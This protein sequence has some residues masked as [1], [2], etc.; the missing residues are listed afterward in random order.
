MYSLNLQSQNRRMKNVNATL[1]TI[2]DEL[3]IGQVID[4]NSSWMAQRLNEIGVAVKKRIAIGDSSQEIVNTLDSEIGSVEV[5]LITGGLGPTS[6]DI[7]KEVLCDYFGGKM[8]IDSKALENVK[9]LF[10]KIYKKPASNVN[11]AQAEV[12][13]VCEV[14]QNQ[15]GSAPGMIFRKNNSVIISMPGVPYEMQG[16]MNDVIPLLQEQFKLPAIIHRTILTFGIGESA[17][18]ELISDFE[19]A[20]PP[21][22]N[23]AYLPNYGMVRLRLSTSGFDK[24]ATQTLIDNEFE[25]L[26]V[27]VVQY[28]VTDRDDS[29][30]VVLGK[31]LL[32]KQKT[33]STAESCTGGAIAS[34][35]SSVPGASA[36]FEGSIVSYSYNIKEKLLDVSNETLNK[37]GAVSEATVIE[38][39]KGLLQNLDTDYGIAVS[40]IMGPGG[41]TDDKPVGTVWVAVGD[42]KNIV[43]QKFQQRYER[44]KNIEVTSVMALNMMRKFIL[45]N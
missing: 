3:L 2:G 7:T 1:I 18:A 39:L 37:Q 19:N 10:E 41:G 4:T 29:M 14:I 44:Y 21:E 33:I 22:I 31:L 40:G 36:Y 30:Q 12:P 24:E 17:L 32:E 5:I 6:D 34:L 11:L 45:S 27:L 20:L 23:L 9:H 42:K 13:D 16:I 25:K 38:M 35:I 15:R 26:K 8:I 28:I 43:T